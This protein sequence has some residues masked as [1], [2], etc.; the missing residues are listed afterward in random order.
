M[1]RRQMMLLAL[2]AV[3]GIAFGGK[4]LWDSYIANPMEKES[5]S[6]AVLAKELRK[7]KLEKKKVTIKISEGLESLRKV[8]LPS[9]LQNARSKYRGWL[10]KTAE[11]C[12]L[13]SPS[14]SVT[15]PTEM[16]GYH[17]FGFSLRCNGNLR[18]LVG[19]LYRFYSSGHLQKLRQ[20][21]VT[22]LSGGQRVSIVASIEAISIDSAEREEE[23]ANVPSDRL[24]HNVEDQYYTIV[25]RNLFSGGQ[26]NKLLRETRLTGVT[27]NAQGVKQAWFAG[28]KQRFRLIAGESWTFESV[29]VKVQ[30]ISDSEVTALINGLETTIKI[31]KYLE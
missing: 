30:S 18:K 4:Y 14:I 17:R 8:S 10:L 22:P 19:F 16:N 25:R 6:E 26:S 20:L 2:L 7:L 23:L 28:P 9:D 5:K 12:E 29:D 24:V 1:E 15:G 3:F 11:D 31:G 27:Q 21:S 13:E